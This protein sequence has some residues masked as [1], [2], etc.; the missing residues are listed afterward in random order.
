[1]RRANVTIVAFHPV[2]LRWGG[3]R[4]SWSFATGF[5]GRFR[6]APATLTKKVSRHVIII[7]TK[8]VLPAGHYYLAHG[9]G[10]L[11]VDS[12]VTSLTIVG[13]GEGSTVIDA[14]TLGDRLLHVAST[15]DPGAPTWRKAQAS[16]LAF[17]ADAARR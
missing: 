7:R 2:D 3:A 17:V 10:E 8:I 13:A 12:T 9:N 5:R 4:V 16:C 6:P 1:M 15:V 11:T 14:S